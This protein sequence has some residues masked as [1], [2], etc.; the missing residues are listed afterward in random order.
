MYKRQGLYSAGVS[1][2]LGQGLLIN[3][4]MAT[5]RKAKLYREQALVDSDI[6]INTILY[7]ASIA[8]FDWLKSYNET[9]IFDEFIKN[10][11]IRFEGVK[12]SAEVGDKAPIDSIEARITM[13][14]R[15]L[16]LEQARLKFVKSSIQLSNFL[17]INDDIPVELQ[18]HVIPDVDIEN[19]CL[20]YTSP[21]PRDA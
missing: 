15:K 17:W 5:L 8:Y 14:N 18:P 7:E 3:E 9:L 12:K 2:S 10:A 16:S 11:K 4:R 6:L 13:Q 19:S 20:L 1:V 21:S